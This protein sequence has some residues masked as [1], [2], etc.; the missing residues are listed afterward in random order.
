MMQPPRFK[1]LDNPLTAR[2]MCLDRFNALNR[3]TTAERDKWITTP[4]GP[5]LEAPKGLPSM[6]LCRILTTPSPDR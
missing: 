3:V 6:Q 2:V 5:G 4:F 1:E